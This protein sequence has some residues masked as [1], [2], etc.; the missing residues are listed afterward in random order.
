MALNANALITVAELRSYIGQSSTE[1]DGLLELLINAVSQECDRY[2]ARALKQATYTNLY[3]DGNGEKTL[4]LPSWPA[5]S[6]GTVTEDGTAL[7]SGLDDDYT[8]YTSD[9]DA[10]LRRITGTWLYGPKT[11]LISSV[12]LG[13]ATIPSDLKLAAMKQTALEW[14]RMK[15]KEWGETS[16]SVGEGSV[17]LIAPGLLPDVEAVLKR[18]RRYGL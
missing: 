6:L 4:D 8:L 12:A 17:S 11:V 5:A 9:S 18:Y 14:Q 10:Y 13:Y 15:K 1:S 7:V 16:R 3:L 2:C